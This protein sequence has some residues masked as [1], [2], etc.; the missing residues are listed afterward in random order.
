MLS[1]VMSAALV[2]VTK[3]LMCLRKSL[4]KMKKACRALWHA[5]L[6]LH[7]QCR[8]VVGQALEKRLC[9]CRISR[10]AAEPPKE[11]RQRP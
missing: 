9:W 4:A 5:G 11:R 7:Q 6:H 2:D 10:G 8:P 3:A 1:A